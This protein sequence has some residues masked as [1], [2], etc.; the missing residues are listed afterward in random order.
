[1]G[2]RV[3]TTSEGRNINDIY[4][5]Y[6][7][8]ALGWSWDQINNFVGALG[9]ALVFSGLGVKRMIGALGLRSFTTMSNVCNIVSMTLYANCPPFSYLMSADSSMWLG[10]LFAIPGARKRDAVEALVMKIGAQEGFGKGFIS[11][12][13]MN[14]R[15]VINVVGPTL[16]GTMYN[17]GASNN[18]PGFVFLVASLTVVAAELTLQTLPKRLFD[19]AESSAT[20][21]KAK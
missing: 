2:N 16:F 8:D 14:W 9:V 11:G 17:F 20:P 10:L 15:A 12:S 7:Q 21:Q 19:E 1:M 18:F 3:Q 4:A 5:L 6:M 13:L